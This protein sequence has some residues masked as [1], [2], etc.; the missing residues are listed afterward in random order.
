MLLLGKT[1]TDCII[2]VF[3]G[4][5]PFMVKSARIHRN[6]QKIIVICQEI[7]SALLKHG[8]PR[9]TSGIEIFKYSSLP[10]ME[11]FHII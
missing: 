11:K 1:P 8:S 5:I 7:F 6:A 2:L 4:G 10:N 9:T 3:L